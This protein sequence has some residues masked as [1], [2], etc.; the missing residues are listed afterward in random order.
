MKIEEEKRTE[1]AREREILSER[2]DGGEWETDG[3][4]R[5]IDFQIADR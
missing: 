1:N 5:W 2:L 4:R 3:R